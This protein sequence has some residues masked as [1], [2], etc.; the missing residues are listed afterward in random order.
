[1]RTTKIILTILSVLLFCQPTL[2]APDALP[3]GVSIGGQQAAMTEASSNHARLAKPVAA[4]AVM[5]VSDVK[6]QIIV[7]IFHS[8]EN[9]DP[10][11]DKQPRILLFDA[12]GSKSMGDNMQGK[13]LTP[14]WYL[15]NV[16]GGG[17]TSRVV[18]QVK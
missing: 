4:D 11:D 18:F 9:G 3:F 15:T 6:G 17:G 5:K 12:A 13:A 7:N 10:T 16:V 14:G 2:A 8:T 1:M